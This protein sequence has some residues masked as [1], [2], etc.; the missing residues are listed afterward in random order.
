MKDKIRVRFRVDG[1]LNTSL[2]LPVEVHSA[3]VARIKIL[4]D[5]KLDEK[6][7][8]QD[9]RFS[10]KIEGRK[11]DFRVSTFPASYGEKV[12]MRILDQEKGVKTLDQMMLSPK[13]L[14][15]VREAMARPY[16]LYLFLVQQVLVKQ[17]LFIL[18]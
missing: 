8:P 17:Q 18:C 10:T 3:V 5:M 4:C 14:Q 9:G 2:I 12:V 16:G 13:N 7:K 15:M 6:R 11:V 1:V